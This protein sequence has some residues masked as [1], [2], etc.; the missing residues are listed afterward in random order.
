MYRAFLLRSRH[1]RFSPGRMINGATTQTDPVY[2]CPRSAVHKAGHGP[3]RM[4]RASSA[5]QLPVSAGAGYLKR[6]IQRPP[7]PCRRPA[8]ASSRGN[9]SGRRAL[10]CTA[11]V[12]TRTRAASISGSA[13]SR[14]RAHVTSHHT[15]SNRGMQFVK[16]HYMRYAY[17]IYFSLLSR[18]KF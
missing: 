8:G 18:F 16:Y 3:S 15:V 9:A 13:V 2:E 6:M 12:R 5:V 10:S 17:K 11:G 14:H 4:A 1:E 7:H